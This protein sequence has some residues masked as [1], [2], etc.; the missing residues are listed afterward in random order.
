MP[1]IRRGVVAATTSSSKYPASIEEAWKYLVR[2]VA[3]GIT[4]PKL[5]EQCQLNITRDDFA[6]ATYFVLGYENREQENKDADAIAAAAGTE[7]SR[8]V[9]ETGHTCEEE[10]IIPETLR[11]TETPE[12]APADTEEGEVPIEGWNDN[13]PEE[14]APGELKGYDHATG[15]LF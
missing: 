8:T 15:M 3:P 7:P 2:T 11:R 1:K 10:P 6:Q 12:A 5:M 4:G 9:C 14:P 13:P